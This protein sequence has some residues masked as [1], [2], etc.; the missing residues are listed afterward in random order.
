MS[1]TQDEQRAVGRC[2]W[3]GSMEPRADLG[4][5]AGKPI[6]RECW[7]AALSSPK[8]FE[9]EPRLVRSSAF[10]LIFARWLE[11]ERELREEELR[12]LMRGDTKD[13]DQWRAQWCALKPRVT[14]LAE[15][16]GAGEKESS[17]L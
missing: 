3:C 15:A 6:C 9:T 14:E 4:Q 2:A 11:A 8:R 7:D 16:I 17:V 13:A 1:N 5:R 12:A 10:V